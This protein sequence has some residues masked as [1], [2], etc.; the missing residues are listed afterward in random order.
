M[1]RAPS[2]YA[3][4]LR[5]PRAVQL[6]ACRRLAVVR[7]PEFGFVVS[8]GRSLRCLRDSFPLGL[9]WEG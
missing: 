4:G 3:A 6:T 1:F 5:D 2:E 8:D 9:E 7:G